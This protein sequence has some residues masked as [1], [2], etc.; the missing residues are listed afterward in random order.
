MSEISG[1]RD[2]EKAPGKM[3]PATSQ[4]K[5]A[6]AA[7]GQ[8]FPQCLDGLRIMLLSDLPGVV[9][10][11]GGPNTIVSIHVGQ[12]TKMIC[13]R[14]GRSHHGTAIHGDIDVI[15][16]GVSG[17]WELKGKDTALV[18]SMSPAFL[19]RAAED[20]G[21]DPLQLGIKKPLSDARPAN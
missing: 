3:R 15:P 2:I 11:A 18:L 21:L 7:L 20:A 9:E 16:S 4:T 19:R 8:T 5:T 17:I 6:F 14:D 13:R 12:S 10:F 1:V